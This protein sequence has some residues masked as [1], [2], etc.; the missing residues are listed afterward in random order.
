[1]L[2]RANKNAC[3]RLGH[4]ELDPLHKIHLHLAWALGIAAV[5]LIINAVA[6]I[7]LVEGR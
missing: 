1:M 4:T 5:V 6:V 7:T 2:H 3:K